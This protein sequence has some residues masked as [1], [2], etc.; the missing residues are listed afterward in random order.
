MTS[1]LARIS[2]CLA[3]WKTYAHAVALRPVVRTHLTKNLKNR[4][5]SQWQAI[6]KAGNVGSKLIPRSDK[7]SSMD[8]SMLVDL[9]L[10]SPTCCTAQRSAYVPILL[11]L[12]NRLPFPANKP[13]HGEKMPLVFDRILKYT[14]I[15]TTVGSTGWSCSWQIPDSRRAVIA[16]LPQPKAV[17]DWPL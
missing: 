7:R 15:A 3:G 1:P 10:L 6:M 17:Q 8:G 2:G 12:S 14:S 5:F 11:I 16:P 9:T 4:M 13:W